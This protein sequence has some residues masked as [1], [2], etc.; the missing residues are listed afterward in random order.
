MTEHRDALVAAIAKQVCDS[1]MWPGQVPCDRHTR[2]AEQIA[3]GSVAAGWI[4]TKRDEP[5]DFDRLVT[6]MKEV[7]ADDTSRLALFTSA[8]LVEELHA[9]ISGTGLAEGTING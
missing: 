3:D 2:Q 7:A 5:S 1:V 6:L 8:E 4:I 9:R